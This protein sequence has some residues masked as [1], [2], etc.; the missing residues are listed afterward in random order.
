MVTTDTLRTDEKQLYTIE[1][2]ATRT[3]FT[4]RTLR[5]YEELGLL[6]PACR[7]E[8]NY[9]RYAESDIQ[10]LE[11]IKEMHELLGFTLT[12]IRAILGAED[13][14]GHIKG[15]YKH[16]TDAAA[17]IA[18]LDCVD[19]LIRSQL[20]RIQRKLAG[21]EQMRSALIAKLEHHKQIRNELL[22]M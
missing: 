19:E 9:R 14:R 2:V 17:K 7:T 10:R 8:G 12:E 4:K 20:Y 6:Q 11:Q 5:Y 15:A 1:Q 21:L 18:R 3:G 13:E 22:D 16:E